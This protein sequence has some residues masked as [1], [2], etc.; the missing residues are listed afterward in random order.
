MK[1][2]HSQTSSGS[3]NQECFHPLPTIS[4]T[5]MNAFKG[6]IQKGSSP[7]FPVSSSVLPQK[8]LNTLSKA[9]FAYMLEQNDKIKLHKSLWNTTLQNL[10]L[11]FNNVFLN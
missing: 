2:L 10:L 7:P 11:T 5:V 6:S 3:N 8:T 4:L 1:K 9:P